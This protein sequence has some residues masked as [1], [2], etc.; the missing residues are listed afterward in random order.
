MV[1][2]ICRI[3]IDFLRKGAFTSFIVTDAV[4]CGRCLWKYPTVVLTAYSLF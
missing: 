4:V 1:F 3:A 2:V